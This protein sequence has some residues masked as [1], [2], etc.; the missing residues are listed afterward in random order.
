MKRFL[1][2]FLTVALLLPARPVQAAGWLD[3]VYEWFSDL[4][5]AD[6]IE[7]TGPSIKVIDSLRSSPLGIHLKE[8]PDSDTLA[9]YGNWP[10]LSQNPTAD[11]ERYNRLLRQSVLLTD[12]D[13]KL[14][15]EPG[16]VRVIYGKGQRPAYFLNMLA[17]FANVQEVE[18]NTLLPEVL[19]VSEALPS[20][21]V[22]EDGLIGKPLDW[23]VPLTDSLIPSATFIHFGTPEAIG[24]LPQEWSVINSPLRCKESESFLAQALFGAE[25][26]DSRLQTTTAIYRAG[27]GFRLSGDRKGF[28]L[29]EQLGIDRTSLDKIDYQINR[30]IRYRAMPGAQMLVMKDGQVVYEKAFGHHTYR[31]QDVSSGDLY[32][33]ASVT[34]AA[35]TS[36]AVMKLFDEGRLDVGKR[37]RDYLPEF[38]RKLV[39]G[40]RID[41]LLTHQTGL[42]PN[43]PVGQFLG[44]QF[45]SDSL[46]ADFSLPIGSDKWLDSRMPE[47]VRASL[48]GKLDYTAR[49]VYRYSDLNYYLLQLVVEAIS[50]ETLDRFVQEQ[51]YRPMGLGRIGYNPYRTYPM[52]LLVPTINE[53]WMRGGLLRGFVHDEGAALL[54]GVAG[55]AG[56]FSNA[57]DLGQLFQLLNNQGT[58]GGVEYLKPATVALF[59][60]HGKYNYR[61][62]GFDRLTGRWG[63]A[64]DYGAGTNTVGHLGFTGTS[65]WADPENDLVFVL[66]TNRVNPDPNNEKFQRM[67]IRSRVTK[68]VYRSLN[69]WQVES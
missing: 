52:D 3:D 23:Y 42:Q 8:V 19:R 10:Y 21:I 16:E 26:I 66:L 2:P 67:D 34:K 57:H 53:P 37:V 69:T 44:R 11:L 50:G 1:L 9:I 12:P 38:K 17:R 28:R 25:L 6:S 5:S 18:F 64:H 24:G 32:D 60:G 59:T 20:I 58:Y 55:H 56:L 49:P 41:Q 63:S 7:P 4:F 13:G 51:Y 36:M 65:V 27:T 14:P 15:F 22:V 61:A 62:L 30:G 40:Y 45:T 47:W 48:T 31:Q 68:E 46:S 54:G 39:G 29:P 43:L 35:A 33:L